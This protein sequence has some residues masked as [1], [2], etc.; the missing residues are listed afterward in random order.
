MAGLLPGGFSGTDE[1][2]GDRIRRRAAAMFAAARRKQTARRAPHYGARRKLAA[3]SNVKKYVE[4]FVVNDKSQLDSR[5]G[6]VEAAQFAAAW[7]AA[8]VQQPWL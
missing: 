5:G 6:V 8:R 1:H 3:P 7:G 2:Y 4:T